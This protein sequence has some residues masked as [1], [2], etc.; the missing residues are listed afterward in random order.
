MTDFVYFRKKKRKIKTQIQIQ[1]RSFF[2]EES[3]TRILSV[4]DPEFPR[5]GAPIQD[6]VRQP[7]TWQHF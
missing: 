5:V 3:A 6:G 2:T 7:I 1:R 4:A